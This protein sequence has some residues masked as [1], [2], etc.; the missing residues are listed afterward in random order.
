MKFF[1]LILVGFIWASCTPETQN[2]N[3]PE[4]NPNCLL[5]SKDNDKDNLKLFSY[6]ALG[7]YNPLS[8]MEN[9]QKSFEEDP[10]YHFIGDDSN[11]VLLDYPLAGKKN[12]AQILVI[13]G[14][15][16]KEDIRNNFRVGLVPDGNKSKTILYHKGFY[17]KAKKLIAEIKKFLKKGMPIY[18]AGHSQGAATAI[19]V[20]KF[21]R[22]DGYDV[23]KVYAFASPKVGNQALIDELSNE[24]NKNWLYFAANEKDP[25]NNLVPSGKDIKNWTNSD[26]YN[27]FKIL[28]KPYAKWL[29]NMFK[30]YGTNLSASSL[31]QTSY[32]KSDAAAIYNSCIQS[33]AFEIYEENKKQGKNVVADEKEFKKLFKRT[34]NNIAESDTFDLAK[35]CYPGSLHVMPYQKLHN[36][37]SILCF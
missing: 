35:F 5:L 9:A 20:G 3:R 26:A 32:S 31:H 23:K 30:G 2:N 21:L 37:G 16:T 33:I 22:E 18:V 15:S 13:R 7:I 11:S 19:L 10:I 36:P 6:L 17:K 28:Y 12:A 29:E 25:V 1:Y 14:T 27:E 8:M 24:Q 34:V 4:S